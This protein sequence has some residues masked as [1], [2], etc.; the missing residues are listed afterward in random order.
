[1]R[2]P[3]LNERQRQSIYLNSALGDFYLFHLTWLNMKREF[4]RAIND[5]RFLK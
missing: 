1:M 4:E 2:K 5:R 3:I